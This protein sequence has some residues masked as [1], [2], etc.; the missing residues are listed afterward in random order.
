MMYI[1]DSIAYKIRSDI[2]L[3]AP[4]VENL[5]IEFKLL[6]DVSCL[7]CSMYRPPSA[8]INYYKG[9]LDIMDR[10]SLENKEILLLGDLNFDYKVDES[11]SSNPVHYIE[12]LYLMQLMITG[13][14]RVTQSSETLIDVLLTTMPEL[15]TH[16]E[17]FEFSLSDH[18]MIYSCIDV[19][20]MKRQ[21]K[22]VRYRCC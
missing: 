3:S 13:K 8:G 20:K 1:R 11:L 9:V 15:H 14:T 5:W 12:N 19:P 10:A 17:V 7:M 22:S 6:M 18:F 16:D 21:H 4:H 2:V